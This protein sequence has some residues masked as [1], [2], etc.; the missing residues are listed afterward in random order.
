MSRAPTESL[1]RPIEDQS[2]SLC[3][4][5]AKLTPVLNLKRV[6]DSSPVAPAASR[7]DGTKP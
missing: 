3:F 2:N 1:F 4:A 6:F 7:V 5:V